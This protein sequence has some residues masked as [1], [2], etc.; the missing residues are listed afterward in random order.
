MMRFGRPSFV[1]TAA[2]TALGVLF[3]IPTPAGCASDCRDQY[4]QNMAEC[5]AQDID[6]NDAEDLRACLA[7]AKDKYQQCLKDCRSSDN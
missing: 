5:R 7:D 6:A 3:S 2:F 4:E 1:Q